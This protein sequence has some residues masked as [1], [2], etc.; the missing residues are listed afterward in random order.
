MFSNKTTKRNFMKV[1]SNSNDEDHDGEE[2][3]T[4]QTEPGGSTS[5]K[6]RM[7]DE[8]EQKQEN[9]KDFVK[10]IILQIITKRNSKTSDDC[11]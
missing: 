6:K 3:I 7:F 5:A 8:M 9:Y 11:T 10:K 2:L 4:E 1:I